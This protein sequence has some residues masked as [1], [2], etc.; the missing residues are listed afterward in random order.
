MTV[1]HDMLLQYPTNLKAV[2]DDVETA[3]SDINGNVPQLK[4][5]PQTN[6]ISALHYSLS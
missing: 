6:D 4:D 5:M 1:F 2:D 3:F